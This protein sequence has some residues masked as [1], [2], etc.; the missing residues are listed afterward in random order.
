MQSRNCIKCGAQGHNIVF[1]QECLVFTCLM[2]GAHQGLVTP[3]SPTRSAL[4][5]LLWRDSSVVRVPRL[6]QKVQPMLSS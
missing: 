1:D 2:C 4:H 3:V 6:P 5:R